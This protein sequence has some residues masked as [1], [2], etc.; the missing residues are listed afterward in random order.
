M[1]KLLIEKHV[2]KQLAKISEPIYSQIKSAINELAINPRPHGYLKLKGRNGYRIKQ[3]NY[4]I[5]YD[6]NDQILTVYILEAGH[7]KDIYD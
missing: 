6:I 4:R 1:Y 7:R 3:G 2:E 5:I